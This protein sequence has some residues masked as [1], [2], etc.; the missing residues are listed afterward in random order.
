MC[1]GT[2]EWQE[3]NFVLLRPR[4][5]CK[6]GIVADTEKIVRQGKDRDE[7]HLQPTETLPSPTPSPTP[8]PPSAPCL[9]GHD[10]GSYFSQSPSFS[11]SVLSPPASFLFLC[12]FIAL[13]RRRLSRHPFFLCLLGPTGYLDRLSFSDIL[14]C[15]VGV[16]RRAEKEK[17]EWC[18][19]DGVKPPDRRRPHL[20]FLPQHFRN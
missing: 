13:A 6:T 14:R 16:A 7:K 15:M 11:H 17:R 20:S 2:W 1:L 4:S 3:E 18:V 12:L 9:D 19:S 5:L 10:P 8:H